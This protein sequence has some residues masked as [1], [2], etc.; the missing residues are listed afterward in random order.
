MT[1]IIPGESWE[2]EQRR[3]DD[4]TVVFRLDGEWGIESIEGADIPTVSH[5][6]RDLAGGQGQ[7]LL[8][9]RV[10]ERQII[11]TV[12]KTGQITSEE[13]AIDLSLL[14]D[15]LRPNQYKP[16]RIIRTRTNGTRIAI[17]VTV[18]DV[19][20]DEESGLPL[21][22]TVSFV[23]H[24]PF[25][26]ATLPTTFILPL[27]AALSAPVAAFSVPSD[28]L[29]VYFQNESTGANARYLWAFGDGGF[30]TDKN[31]IYEYGA[32]AT[33]TVRLT[34]YN[35]IGSDVASEVLS[36]S[37]PAS[38]GQVYYRSRQQTIFWRRD[39]KPFLWEGDG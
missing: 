18:D 6:S 4:T 37:Q 36:L 15:M 33:Y 14:V 28:G 30:S 7:V 8:S 35:D 20:S 31:P 19:E 23:A 5:Q 24:N 9:S 12:V 3:A 34:A 29:T 16:L 27:P 32:G 2:L 13:R 1:Q 11:F 26:Y 39:D 22:E 38:D 21:L 10:D 17:E 25:W